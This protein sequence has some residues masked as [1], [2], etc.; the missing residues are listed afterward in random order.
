MA[1]ICAT[2]QFYGDVTRP[3]ASR[4]SL[5]LTGYRQLTAVADFAVQS[6]LHRRPAGRI[7]IDDHVY[8]AAVCH[9]PRA[10]A[11]ASARHCRRFICCDYHAVCIIKD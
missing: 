10:A 4:S 8:V 2:S 5:T 6:T 3:T 11:A 7:A 1:L 9:L